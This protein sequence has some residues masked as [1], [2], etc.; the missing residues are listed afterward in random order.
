MLPKRAISIRGPRFYMDGDALTFVNHFDG[1][2]REGP[3][4]ATK[5]DSEAHP[6]AWANFACGAPGG[7]LG[8]MVTFVTPEGSEPEVAPTPHAARR[9][10][11]ARGDAA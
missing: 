9:A 6:E 5:E 3:R 7:G 10:K 2:T 11:A 8:S 4:P 1:F